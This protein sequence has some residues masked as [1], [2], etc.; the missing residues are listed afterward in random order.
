MAAG[1]SL[2]TLPGDI[3]DDADVTRLADLARG[4][5]G[6]DVLINCA[7][8]FPF[9]MFSDITPSAGARSSRYSSTWRR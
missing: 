7:G 6:L 3:T 5:G 2:V 9:D 4:H 1:T 8:F